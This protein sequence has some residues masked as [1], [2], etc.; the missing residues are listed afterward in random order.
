MGCGKR[1][2]EGLLGTIADGYKRGVNH[3]ARE[4]GGGYGLI[5]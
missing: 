4:I 2:E 3:E 1:E 5:S